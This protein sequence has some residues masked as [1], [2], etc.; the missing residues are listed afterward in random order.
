VLSLEPQYGTLRP[1]ADGADTWQVLQVRRAA[2]PL[3]LD[4]TQPLPYARGLGEDYARHLRVAQLVEAE[5]P[6]RQHSVTEK[7][8]APLRRLG[9]AARMGLT[10]GEA[11][12]VLAA[13]LGD[14]DG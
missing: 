4:D 2:I 13:V 11:T 3:L 9:T 8:T 12:D 10:Q 5:A 1:D 14:W 6:W 7:Q